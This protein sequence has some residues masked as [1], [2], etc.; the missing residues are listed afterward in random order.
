VRLWLTLPPGRS[1][2][3]LDEATRERLRALGYVGG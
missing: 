2:G 3:E 1:I